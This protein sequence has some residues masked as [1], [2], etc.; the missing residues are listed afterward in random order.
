M[1]CELA[2]HQ[3]RIAHKAGLTVVSQRSRDDMP[4]AVTASEI[5]STTDQ[6]Q[7]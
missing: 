1:V 4:A 5:S 3:V 2:V 6:P 7:C